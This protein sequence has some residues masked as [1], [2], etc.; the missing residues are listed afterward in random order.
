MA[1][2]DES[3]ERIAIPERD[4]KTFRRGLVLFI[5][6]IT[7]YALFTIAG[8]V[9][10]EILMTRVWGMNLGI[11]GGMAIIAGAIAIAVYYNW[12][13]GKMEAA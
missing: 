8:T 6:Y 7:V 11:V 13:A 4:K 12:Y 9:R 5:V 3:G 2:R 1:E 10:K